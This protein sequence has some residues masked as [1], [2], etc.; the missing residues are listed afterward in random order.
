MIRKVGGGREPG[1]CRK[2]NI[3]CQASWV[4]TKAPPLTHWGS[5][6]SGVKVWRALFP[7]L[8]SGNSE[9]HLARTL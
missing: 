7:H 5:L 2:E 4:P 3:P 6:V 1:I 8:R 9:I